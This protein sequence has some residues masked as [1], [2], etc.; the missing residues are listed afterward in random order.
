[1]LTSGTQLAS[2]ST[3]LHNG[4]WQPL[5]GFETIYMLL[6]F[7]VTEATVKEIRDCGFAR[8]LRCGLRRRRTSRPESTHSIA[9]EF[10]F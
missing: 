10:I 3:K 2:I 9:Y 5:K 4:R 6:M 1:M 8:Y 7:Q